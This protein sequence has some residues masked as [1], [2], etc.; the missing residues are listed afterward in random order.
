[1]SI[2]VYVMEKVR[3][4][5]QTVGRILHTVWTLSIILLLTN[6]HGQIVCLTVCMQAR[7][8]NVQFRQCPILRLAWF[9][10]PLLDNDIFPERI[11]QTFNHTSIVYDNNA[12]DKD[13]KV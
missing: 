10:E 1:M 9:T 12:Q 11:A 2:K 13:L 3:D 7:I 5:V 8:D 6:P 4:R